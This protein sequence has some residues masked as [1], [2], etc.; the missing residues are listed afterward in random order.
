ML[1][2]SARSI[3][4][5][6]AAL[7]L[8]GCALLAGRFGDLKTVDHVDLARYMGHW[9]VIAN[10][11]YFAE[12]D[13]FDSIESYA[14]RPDGDIDNWFDCRKKSASAPLA[15]Q[16]QARAVVVNRSTQAEWNVLFFGFLKIKYVVLAIDPDYQWI[17]VGHPSRHYGW[18]MA[19]GTSLPDDTYARILAVFAEQGYDISRFSKV[20]QSAVPVDPAPFDPKR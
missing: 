13:C 7:M 10:I 18:V 9:R 12:A 2:R 1:R 5:G 3:L 8:A 20:P 4:V 16:A 17:A 14:L 19:R 6:L 11:P 15:R